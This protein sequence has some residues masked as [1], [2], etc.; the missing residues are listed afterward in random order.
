MGP[1][2]APAARILEPVR[3]VRTLLAAL[4]LLAGACGALGFGPGTCHIKV[5]SGGLTDIEYCAVILATP[6]I[7]E[8]SEQAQKAEAL[9]L[10][11]DKFTSYYEFRVIENAKGV[12]IWEGSEP[13]HPVDKLEITPS[14]ETL[15]L[16]IDVDMHLFDVYQ[17]ASLG[18]LI[19]HGQDWVCI[20]VSKEDML[21][22]NNPKPINLKD[23][24]QR[25]G[26]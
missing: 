17:G 21:K 13:V 19:R 6:D 5:Q 25:A 16:A 2:S 24:L 11:Q 3:V 15:S 1:A 18:L 26:S 9:I 23:R 4:A 14:R 20:A 10:Q 8:G 7:F 22:T 12:P